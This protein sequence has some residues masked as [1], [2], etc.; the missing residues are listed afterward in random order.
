MELPIVHSQVQALM[1]VQDEM[2]RQNRM[3]GP[4]SERSDV[5]QG[6]LMRAGMAQ[7]VSLG[8][9]QNGNELAFVVTP[10][11]YPQDWSGFRDYGSDV[12]NLA[13]AAAFLLQEMARKIQAGEDRTRLSRNPETQPFSD[14]QTAGLPQETLS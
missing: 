7:L 14:T 6:Q 3:W 8:A 10:G 2:I 13:V 1:A 4:T 12:A 11:I 9:R 5:A